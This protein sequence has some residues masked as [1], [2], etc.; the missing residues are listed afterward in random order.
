LTIC[1]SI[2]PIPFLVKSVCRKRLFVKEMK[3]TV[4]LVL[5]FILSAE[6]LYNYLVRS[7]LFLPTQNETI[8]ERLLYHIK[9]I[10]VVYDPFSDSTKHSFRSH[11]AIFSL[12]KHILK[13]HTQF[14]L[15]M[16]SMGSSNLTLIVMERS[17]RY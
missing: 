2:S 12:H 17:E 10:S 4:D 9:H 11:V 13:T 5:F 1:L 14:S 16:S 3:S 7:L 6:P 8:Y 15:S